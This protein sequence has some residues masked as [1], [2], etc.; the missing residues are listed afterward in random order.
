MTTVNDILKQ[1]SQNSLYS[2]SPDTSVYDALKMMGEKNA[3]S[4]LVLDSSGNMLGIFTERDYARK[5]V[6]LGKKSRETMVKDIMTPTEKIVS[7][8]TGSS[9]DDCMQQMTGNKIRHLPVL[10]NGKPVTVI[11]IGDV[12]FAV[13]QQQKETI[14]HLSSYIQG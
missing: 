3:G 10:E 7:V 1:R 6:L 8:T 5:I 2:V 11:S 14:S 4:V 13:I 9:L 12:V